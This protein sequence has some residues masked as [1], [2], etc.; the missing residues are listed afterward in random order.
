[1]ADAVDPKVNK[2]AVKQ[3]ILLLFVGVSFVL[4]FL[5]WREALAEPGESSPGYIRNTQLVSTQNPAY[6]EIPSDRDGEEN[7]GKAGSSGM[8]SLTNTAT[9]A[10]A[11]RSHIPTPTETQIPLMDQ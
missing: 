10:Q 5:L 4:V 1:M 6:K 7:S 11:D 9:P 8:L 2:E 3:G